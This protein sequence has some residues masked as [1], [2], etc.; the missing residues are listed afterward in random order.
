MK[1]TDQQNKM[2]LLVDEGAPRVESAVIIDDHPMAAMA[3]EALLKKH[4]IQVTNKCGDGDEGLA[5]LLQVKP[6]VAIIDIDVPGINGLEV[7]K[8]ARRAGIKSIL[9]VFSTK[10]DVFYGKKCVAAGANGFVSKKKGMDNIINAIRAAR[11]GY[12]YFPFELNY[13]LGN[14][15]TEESLI[16]ALSE[17][18][19]NVLQYLLRGVTVGAVAEAMGINAKTVSTYKYRLM[20]KLGCNS[21]VELL[22]F[23]ARNNIR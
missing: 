3:L 15:T 18:E 8:S 2:S 16:D 6:D 22:D 7:I 5:T 1:D 13:F 17:Q 19:V 10:N 4:G 9:V 21:I 12:S 14:V 23:S 11:N 20:Q